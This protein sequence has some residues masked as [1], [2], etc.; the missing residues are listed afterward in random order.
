M[1]F[2]HRTN[3]E[4]RPNRFAAALNAHRAAGRG[5]LD[6]TV[7]NPPDAKLDYDVEGILSA[8]R[9]LK[10][11]EYHPEPKGLLCAREA[12]AEYYAEVERKA[13]ARCVRDSQRVSS[14]PRPEQIVLTT[15]TSEAYT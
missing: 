8:F 4:L 7:S 10:S 3:W 13:N 12:V 11:L 5:V 2:A 1:K 6:L 15:S 9:N 14:V